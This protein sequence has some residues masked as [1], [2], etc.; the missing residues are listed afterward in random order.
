MKIKTMLSNFNLKKT[1]VDSC[2][3]ISKTNNN[4]LIVSI[5]VDDGLHVDEVTSS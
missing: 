5:F 4:S 2:V 1:R 3:F